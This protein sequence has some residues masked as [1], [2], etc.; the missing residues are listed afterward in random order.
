MALVGFNDGGK[1]YKLY[2]VS[3]YNSLSYF[4]LFLFMN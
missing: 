3:F 2:T 1:V 4:F